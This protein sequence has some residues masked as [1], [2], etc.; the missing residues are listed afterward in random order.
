MNQFCSI[1]DITRGGDLSFYSES[2]RRKWKHIFY[3]TTIIAVSAVLG[4]SLLAILLL[5]ILLYRKRERDSVL[6]INTHELQINRRQEENCEVSTSWT[7]PYVYRHKSSVIGQSHKP[8]L[9]VTWSHPY[10][11]KSCTKSQ[12]R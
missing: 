12:K 5:V 1:I 6:N 2:S 8:G 11:V 10:W 4:M 9:S 7:A 3:Q